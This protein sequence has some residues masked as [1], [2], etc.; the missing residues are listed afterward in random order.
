M[1]SA[2]ISIVGLQEVRR[3]GA[4]ET[5]IDEYHLLWSR[6]TDGERRLRGVGLVLSH[7]S[8]AALCTWHP[9]NDLI[10]VASLKYILE[11]YQQWMFMLP[12]MKLPN[13]TEMT[14]IR[15]WSQLCCL[16]WRVIWW[17]VW[18]ILTQFPEGTLPG[19]TFPFGSRIPNYNMDRCIRFVIKLCHVEYSGL[20]TGIVRHC[21]WIMLYVI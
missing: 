13:L 6:P 4:R 19:G 15:I 20:F 10:L 21:H 2:N 7:I 18:V 12:Q 17:F 11:I 9:V 5:Q 1:E 16:R 14:F 8:A 3:S